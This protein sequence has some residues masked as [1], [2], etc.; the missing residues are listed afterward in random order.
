LKKYDDS[1]K[2]PAPQNDTKTPA[3]PMPSITEQPNEDAQVIKNGNTL[4]EATMSITKDGEDL[5]SLK[6]SYKDLAKKVQNLK[7]YTNF[8]LKTKKFYG[9]NPNNLKVGEIPE[10]VTEY[11]AMLNLH[12]E[13]T[14]KLE[15]INQILEDRLAN[16]KTER[17]ILGIFKF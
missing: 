4:S 2:Q 11:T 1:N 8:D 3:P 14:K 12:K 15:D 10:L 5:D 9:M 13:L 17:K 7:V 6:E 16:K